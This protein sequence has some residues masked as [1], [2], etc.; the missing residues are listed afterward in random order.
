MQIVCSRGALHTCSDL[1]GRRN[2]TC[3]GACAL[4]LIAV[5]TLPEAA[6]FTGC[7]HYW[8]EYALW[9]EHE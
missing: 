5:M 1:L 2:A 7:P 4:G 3:S 8:A 6:L 9:R